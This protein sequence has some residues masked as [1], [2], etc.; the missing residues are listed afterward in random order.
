MGALQSGA[1]SEEIYYYQL[2]Q[3]EVFPQTWS[4]EDEQKAKE[5]SLKKQIEKRDAMIPESLKN[6]NKNERDNNQDDNNDK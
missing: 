4:F 1:I 6:I 3:Y 5:E 2:K